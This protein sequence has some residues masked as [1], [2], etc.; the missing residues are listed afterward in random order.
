MTNYVAGHHQPWLSQ[1]AAAAGEEGDIPG[2]R[3]SMLWHR[4]MMIPGDGVVDNNTVVVVMVEG[5]AQGCQAC[6]HASDWHSL[7]QAAGW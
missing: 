6:R 1:E 5:H 4:V 2:E 7:G 3:E